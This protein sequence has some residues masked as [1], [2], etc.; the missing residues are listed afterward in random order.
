MPRWL[1]QGSTPPCTSTR[2]GGP[3]EQVGA[4][5]PEGSGNREEERGTFEKEQRSGE[6]VVRNMSSAGDAEH[7]QGGEHRSH[8]GERGQQDPGKP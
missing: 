3:A 1:S 7:R 5:D 6:I 4:Y 2:S 8:S